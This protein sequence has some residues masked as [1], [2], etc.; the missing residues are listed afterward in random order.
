VENAHENTQIPTTRFPES[1]PLASA[2]VPYQLWDGDHIPP[3]EALQI[4]T[5][6]W[7]LDFP[8]LGDG[9]GELD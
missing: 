9:G 8:F 1:M 7:D 5:I 4:G 2:Y 3:E 6:F